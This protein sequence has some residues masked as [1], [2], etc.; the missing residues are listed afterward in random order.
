MGE[1]ETYTIPHEGRQGGR[2]ALHR[3]APKKRS[4]A[5]AAL[6]RVRVGDHADE[7]AA[8]AKQLGGQ[9]LME[10]FDVMEHG[11]MAIIQDPTGAIFCLWQAKQHIGANV[12]RTNGL[13]H[14]DRADDDGH[15]Q[16]RKVLHRALPW[17]TPGH[18]DRRHMVTQLF[19]R[20]DDQGAGGMMPI[21][22]Q[23]QAARAELADSYF[24][25][26][27]VDKSARR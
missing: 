22:K 13:A 20:S 10:P 23:A 16:G 8:K 9:V 24:A 19:K 11:R 14:L 25:V 1:G 3:C 7:S 12:T 27:D 21:P 15:G 17:T 26:E 5:A 2:S 18:D 6:E 4:R